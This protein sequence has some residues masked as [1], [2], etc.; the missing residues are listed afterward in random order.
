MMSTST[1][2]M[3]NHVK[4]KRIAVINQKGGVGKTTTVF[5]LGTGLARLGKSIL[6]VDMDP[7]AHLTHAFGFE[8]EHIQYSVYD[9]MKNS[10]RLED[11]IIRKNGIELIPATLELSGAEFEL[12]ATPGRE[13]LLKEVLETVSNHDFVLIDCPPSLGLLTL[14]ALTATSE[15]YIPLQPEYLALQSISQLMKTVTVVKKR[16]NPSLEITGILGT[17]FDSRKRLNKEVLETIRHHFGNKVFNTIIRDN[18]ALAESPGYG[19]P[20]Y[21][22]KPDSIGAEDY[23]NLCHEV[24]NR[25]KL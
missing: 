21:D 25:Y 12:S 1:E 2:Y 7:Q 24:L 13:W 6:L 18:I 4:N 17:R 14:N 8:T 11:V 10:C 22:Y 23:M 20:I 15:I 19:M 9:L 16:L 3:E 5:N